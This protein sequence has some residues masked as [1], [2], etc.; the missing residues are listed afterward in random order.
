MAL[1]RESATLVAMDV[2]AEDRPLCALALR[3]GRS[4]HC[5]GEECPLWEKD[6]CSL[7]RLSAEGELYG[8]VW[9]EEALAS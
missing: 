4:E 6:G 2:G 5:P 3:A 8:D 9:L 1:A 7:E